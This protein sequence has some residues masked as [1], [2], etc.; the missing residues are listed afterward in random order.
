MVKQKKNLK[1]QMN[2]KT[3][4]KV[5]QDKLICYFLISFLRKSFVLCRFSVLGQVSALLLPIRASKGSKLNHLQQQIQLWLLVR[6]LLPA[7][8][9]Y[10]WLIVEIWIDLKGLKQIVIPRSEKNQ[11]ALKSYTAINYLELRCQQVKA[12][13]FVKLNDRDDK[14]ALEFSK[15]FLVCLQCESQHL[16][17]GAQPRILNAVL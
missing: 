13:S 17:N 7:C 9:V 15:T 1:Y 11:H 16:S 8:Q 10:S 3:C 6:V 4:Y 14:C 5:V 12:V 2:K